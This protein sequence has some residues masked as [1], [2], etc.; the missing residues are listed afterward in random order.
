MEF[1]KLR[2]MKK[3]FFFF[4]DGKIN[5]VVDCR[6]ICAKIWACSALGK[7]SGGIPTN[8]LSHIVGG[9]INQFFAL[10]PFS[11]DLGGFEFSVASGRKYFF[12]IESDKTC[13]YDRKTGKQ[14]YQ[15]ISVRACRIASFA[16]RANMHS[17]ADFQ[18]TIGAWYIGSGSCCDVEI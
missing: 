1:K 3:D 12:D 7:V 5:Y 18:H 13:V 14:L 15:F 8:T 2:D 17:C 6:A 9:K 11:W 4:K 16:P 10:N